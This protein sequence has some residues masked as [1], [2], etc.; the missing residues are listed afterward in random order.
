MEDR[1]EQVQRAIDSL[2]DE[3]LVELVDC[4]FCEQL[5]MGKGLCPSA[6]EHL[7]KLTKLEE[8]DKE[9]RAGIVPA[10]IGNILNL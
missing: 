10:E 3:T 7:R 8:W 4:A 9:L 6:Q 2:R 5:K 1:I